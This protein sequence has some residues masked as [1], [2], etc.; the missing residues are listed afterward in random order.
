MT[1]T[2]VYSIPYAGTTAKLHFTSLIRSRLVP[3]LTLEFK[4][5]LDGINLQLYSDVWAGAH[6]P[7]ATPVWLYSCLLP[8]WQVRRFP[9]WASA[10]CRTKT[11]R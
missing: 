4:S 3:S 5:D 1:D 11:P 6:P 10:L 2:V 9:S 8:G 7:G